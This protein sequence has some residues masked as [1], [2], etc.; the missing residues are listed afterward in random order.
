MRIISVILSV[1]GLMV[2]GVSAVGF[3]L[4]M[5]NLLNALLSGE[6]SGIG[7]V[8]SAITTANLLSYVNIF[9]CALI[10]LGI[11]LNIFSMFGG[12]KQNV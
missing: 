11:L 7:Q 1:I 9:G 8:A 2:C 10:F 4:T 5:S 3:R 12:K 6:T